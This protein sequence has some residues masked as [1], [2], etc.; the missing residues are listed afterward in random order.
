MKLPYSFTLRTVPCTVSPGVNW[1]AFS[2]HVPSS[3]RSVMVIR[4]FFRS[5]DRTAARIFS[6]SRSRT[7]EC[8][9]REIE[10]SSMGK[11]AMMPQPMSKKAP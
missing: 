3:S 11:I 8:W 5:K 9:I 4:R 6:P 1:L 7:P 10:I 2:I